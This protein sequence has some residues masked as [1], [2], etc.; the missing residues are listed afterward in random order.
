MTDP[1]REQLRILEAQLGRMRGMQVVYSSLFFRQITV[2]G[3]LSIALLALSTTADFSPV[4]AAVPFIVPFAFLEAGYALYYVLFARRH[5]EFLERAINRE[6]GSNLLVAH[7]LESAYFT[8][9]DAPKI[10]LFSFGRP[11][12]FASAITLGYTVAAVL[13]WGASM[14]ATLAQV[15]AGGVPQL[16][17]VLATLWSAAVAAYLLW[18]FLA[19]RDEERL[20]HELQASYGDGVR[21]TRRPQRPRRRR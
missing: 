8:P 7:R 17:P 18:H 6:I 5:A 1:A 15:A 2:W 9:M 19:R 3:V 10:A 14:D 20:L 11:A 13:L 12:G 21:S 16:L 4:V